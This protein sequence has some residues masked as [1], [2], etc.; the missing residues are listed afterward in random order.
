LRG[1]RECAV[2][3]AVGTGVSLPS[4]DRFSRELTPGPTGDRRRSSLGWS[5]STFFSLLIV[6]AL[7]AC[8]GGDDDTDDPDDGLVATDT[9]ESQ[10]VDTS[11]PP[12]ESAEPPPP[13]G[14]QAPVGLAVF[15]EGRSLVGAFQALAVS[16]DGSTA[17]YRLT[18]GS[19]SEPFDSVSLTIEWNTQAV[20]FGGLLLGVDPTAGE[21]LCQGEATACEVDEEGGIARISNLSPLTGRV[22]E[23]PDDAQL[24]VG[25]V[26]DYIVVL[27]ITGSP[28]G[29]GATVQTSVAAA[30]SG[31][32]DAIGPV[33]EAFVY[34][35]GDFSIDG[36]FPDDVPQIPDTASPR[37][38]L[39]NTSGQTL[40]NVAFS[41]IAS[42]PTGLEFLTGSCNTDVQATLPFG[43]QPTIATLTDLE[44]CFT[45]NSF[46]S[47]REL[48]LE[49]S[50]K[51]EDPAA[52][53][54]DVRLL[55][56]A[57][58]KDDAGVVHLSELVEL[59]RPAL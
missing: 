43:D 31:G 13:A 8:G 6:V 9:V 28:A 46:G 42:Q 35:S 36:S 58:G 33:G 29:G 12:P 50:L 57:R 3:A 10:P 34:Q 32:D 38:F 4:K 49:A 1:E 41:Y 11:T 25:E 59:V 22:F 51:S 5:H 30:G 53:A 55:L 45:N 18:L 16:A 27:P 24:Q 47:G 15:A 20:D 17:Y 21:D 54:G 7:T 39:A 52:L 44:F 14:L 40:Q 48:Q 26:L 19:S 37:V 23:E 2:T 56:A